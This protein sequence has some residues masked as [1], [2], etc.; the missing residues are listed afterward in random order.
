[1]VTS[2]REREKEM[3]KQDLI[4]VIKK[5]AALPENQR[6]ELVDGVRFKSDVIWNFVGSDVASLA[7][8]KSSPFSHQDLDE[9]MGEVARMQEQSDLC[10]LRSVIEK[11]QSKVDK[12]QEELSA[13]RRKLQSIKKRPVMSRNFS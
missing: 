8:F 12:L 9:A 10:I 1:M 13:N 6:S 11:Q 5:F 7:I 3:Q 2:N 4:E